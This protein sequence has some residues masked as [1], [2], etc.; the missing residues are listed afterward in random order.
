M[1]VLSFCL[2]FAFQLVE[3]IFLKMLQ[4]TLKIEN[5]TCR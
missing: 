2:M 5:N 1:K 3:A 4:V